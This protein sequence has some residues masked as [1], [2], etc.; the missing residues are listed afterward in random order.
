MRIAD[1]A[2]FYAEAGGGVKTYIEAKL[3]AGAALGVEVVVIAPGPSDGEEARDGGRV[4]WVKSRP[5]PGDPRYFLFTSASK[6]HAA[7]DRARPDVVEGSS[8][9]G[10]AWFAASW[11]GAKLKSLVFHQDPVAALA[12]PIL[13][14]YLPAP[15]IDQLALPVWAYLRRLAGRFDHTVVAGAWLEKRLTGFGLPRVTAVPFGIDP[16]PFRAARRDPAVRASWLARLGLPE[17]GYLLVAVSRHHPEKRI[18]VL[19]EAIRRL[20]RLDTRP[21]GLVVFG[22]GP[23]RPRVERAARATRRVALAGYT[24]DR[25]T[26]ATALKSAD[27]FLHGS[28]AETFGLVVSEALAAGLPLVVPTSGGAAELADPS[29]SETYP[30]GDADACAEAIER[31]VTRDAEALRVSVVRAGGGVRTLDEHF[32]ALFELYRSSVHHP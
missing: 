19:I 24:R 4:V 14:R 21:V 30:A 27:A 31:L 6:V 17:T 32:A 22:D 16:T 18:P 11:P 5:V 3:R 29:F 9:Y 8:P 2:E 25:A 23:D 28:A 7:L 13:D 1:V 26:L 10:G 12:H 20:E 15:R